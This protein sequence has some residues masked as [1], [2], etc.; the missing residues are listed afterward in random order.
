MTIESWHTL[1]GRGGSLL[2]MIAIGWWYARR[3]SNTPEEYFL[4]NLGLGSWV[5]ALRAE[6][7]DMS[8]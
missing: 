4:G 1:F 6:A 7:S 3:S 5:A 8:G 2:V